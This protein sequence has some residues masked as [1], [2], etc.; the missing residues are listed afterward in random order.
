M[1]MSFSALTFLKHECCICVM[2]LS[3]ELWRLPIDKQHI[4]YTESVAYS[5]REIW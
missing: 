3:V 1:I 5:R 4:E 2:E